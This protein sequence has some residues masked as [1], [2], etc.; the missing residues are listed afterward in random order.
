MPQGQTCRCLIGYRN[1]I[2]IDKV[3]H[4]ECSACDTCRATW[5]HVHFPN[6]NSTDQPN[7]PQKSDGANVLTARWYT[8]IPLTL[9]WCRS[10]IFSAGWTRRFRWRRHDSQKPCNDPVKICSCYREE[11]SDEYDDGRKHQAVD[12]EA[13]DGVGHRRTQRLGR[14]STITVVWHTNLPQHQHRRRGEISPDAN[15]SGRTEQIMT[16]VIFP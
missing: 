2:D 6:K 15:I 13:E 10:R 1:R 7:N 8:V 11:N 12:S 3:E 9:G 5:E 16:L 4:A 14:C